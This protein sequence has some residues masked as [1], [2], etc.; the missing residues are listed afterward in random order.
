MVPLAEYA[1]VSEEA[2]LLEAVRALE[3]AQKAFDQQRYRHRAILVLEKEDRVTGKLS[4]HDV[5]KAL[6]PN[7]QELEK[8]ERKQLCRYGCFPTWCRFRST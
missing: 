1:M 4:K 8:D 2:T 5:I 7:Y 6:E 3:E